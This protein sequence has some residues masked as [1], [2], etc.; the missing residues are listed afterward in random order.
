VDGG[1]GTV[2]KTAGGGL[3][4]VA[5]ASVGDQTF[6]ENVLVAVFWGLHLEL[7]I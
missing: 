2:E 1:E 5:A 7:F 4:W 6:I 3:V